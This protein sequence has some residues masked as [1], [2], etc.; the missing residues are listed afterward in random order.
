MN[1]LGIYIDDN[2]NVIE[3]FDS[4]PNVSFHKQSGFT[5]INILEERDDNE[6]EIVNSHVFYSIKGLYE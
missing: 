3:V 2:G 5:E 4:T 1:K 6:T